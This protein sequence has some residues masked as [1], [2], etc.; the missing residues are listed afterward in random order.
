MDYVIVFI[1]GALASGSALLIGYFGYLKILRIEQ[2]RVRSWNA[3][4][5]ADA[6]IVANRVR[7]IEQR[8]FQAE[9]DFASRLSQQARTFEERE[10][11]FN[12]RLA[13]QS[14]E[15]EERKR[16]CN[17]AVAR[18]QQ[19]AQDALTA[20]LRDIQER[21]RVCNASLAAKAREMADRQQQLR[22]AIAAFEKRRITYDDMVRENNGLKQDC[23]NLLVRAKKM[24]RDHAAITDRQNEIAERASQLAA[25]YL[26]ESV[27]WIG[28]RLNTTNFSS[29]KQRLVDVIG[30]CR[31]IGFDVP[32][33]QEQDLVQNLQSDFEQAVRDE[34][35]RQE[36]AR[37]KAQIREEEKLAREIDKQIKDA[38]RE[39]AAIQ[40]ALEKALKE[41]KDEHSAEVDLLKERL[42]EAEEKAQR[43]ISQAQLT[44]AGNVYVLSNI[45]SFGENVYKI[46]MTRRLDPMDRVKELGDA[47]VP[48]PFD[49]HMMISCDDAPSLENALHR[50]FHKQR[51]NK[52]NFRKEFFRVNLD[53]IYGIVESQHGK[54]EYRAEPEALQYRESVNMPDADYEFVERTVESVIGDSNASLADEE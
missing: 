42:R 22:D 49:V 4:L 28:N 51:M 38:E 18:K 43:A 53:A 7:A 40:A 10:R 13:L 30:S 44:K 2:R 32:E 5:T 37:I 27:A 23:F 24:D 34:F 25:R 46:G 29:C 35:A 15:F 19:Q 31:S 16:V 21:E 45:G 20:S 36:Q 6:A 48:F 14:R 9:E 41:A 50:E 52:V 54:V 17:D 11:D 33:Q 1:A 47:S 39:K 8:E 12:N 26:K 3:R